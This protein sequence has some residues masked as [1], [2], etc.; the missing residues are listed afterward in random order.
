VRGKTEITE[1]STAHISEAKRQ[2][3]I[4][5]SMDKNYKAESLDDPDLEPLWRTIG[6]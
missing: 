5:F 3:S 4:A 2:L 6:S 1:A